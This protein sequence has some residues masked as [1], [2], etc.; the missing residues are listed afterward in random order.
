MEHFNKQRELLE[1]AKFLYTT[2]FFIT[3]NVEA[4]METAKYAAENNKPLGYNLS[5]TF[6]LQFHT[7]QVDNALQYAD[8]VFGNED[9]T[10]VY[11]EVHGIKY[12]TLQEVAVIIAKSKKVNTK[13]PRVVVITQ[14]SD[15]VICVQYQE[16]G[17]DE[18]FETE[19]PKIEKVLDSNG[20]GDSFVGGF[21]AA[22]T[23]GKDIKTSISAGIWLSA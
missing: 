8:Y 23:Q 6:L 16:G 14:G 9:E 5:A 7:E 3:S 18:V 15:P 12:T 11:A 13:R 2:S 20:A 1:K 10:K 4:L 21:Y 19:V 22:L 17:I